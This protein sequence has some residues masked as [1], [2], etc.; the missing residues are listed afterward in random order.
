MI[1][2]KNHE[3]SAVFVSGTLDMTGRNLE[4]RTYVESDVSLGTSRLQMDGVVLFGGEFWQHQS[5]RRKLGWR[6]A[7]RSTGETFCEANDADGQPFIPL[8]SCPAIEPSYQGY[9]I[10]GLGRTTNTVADIVRLLHVE[11]DTKKH[12]DYQDTSTCASRT[13]C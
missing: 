3:R 11:D 6:V 8:K 12:A 7:D 10:I 2:I 9:N 1:C 5:E 13:I 4:F